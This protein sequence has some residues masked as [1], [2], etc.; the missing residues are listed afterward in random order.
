MSD[1]LSPSVL[2]P[3]VPAQTKTFKFLFI[4][5]GLD[6]LSLKSNHME[7][8][9]FVIQILNYYIVS[10][11]QSLSSLQT[12]MY[13]RQELLISVQI[14]DNSTKNSFLKCS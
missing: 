13:T 3:V 10:V 2:V 14:W 7:S 5:Y 6:V 8:Y 1:C 9:N 11:L 4:S 12:I